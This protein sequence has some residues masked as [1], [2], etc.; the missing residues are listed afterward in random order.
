MAFSDIV[1]N[2]VSSV[3]TEPELRIAS[4]ARL[5]RSSPAARA[6]FSSAITM[7]RSPACG[8]S[9][10]PVICTGVA[11]NASANSIPRS[12]VIVRTRP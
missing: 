11:G 10:I 9:L 5:A 8:T 4:C 1:L 6:V 12:F 2:N 7:N 3:T